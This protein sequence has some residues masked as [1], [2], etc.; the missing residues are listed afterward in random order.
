[1]EKYTT[2]KTKLSNGKTF[3]LYSYRFTE[4]ERDG[5]KK[6]LAKFPE[7]KVERFILGLEKICVWAKAYLRNRNTTFQ[8]T[9]KKRMLRQFEKTNRELL[10]LVD[11][12]VQIQEDKNILEIGVVSDEIALERDRLYWLMLNAA[13]QLQEICKIIKEEYSQ[14]GRPSA[15][16]AT[17]ELVKVI[18]HVYQNLFEKPTAYT[19]G[20]FSAVLRIVFSACGV[21]ITSKDD[22]GKPDYSSAEPLRHIKAALK[23]L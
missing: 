7:E 14:P 3:S 8:R 5:F 4:D 23:A 6:A 22:E 11:R 17:G 1:M 18:A 10:Q 19:S 2:S 9:E 16:A 13:N 21:K 20:P 15:D 12:K